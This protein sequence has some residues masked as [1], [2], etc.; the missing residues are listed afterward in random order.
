MRKC[1]CS[2]LPE[3]GLRRREARRPLFS[4]GTSRFFFNVRLR[5]K[6][7]VPRENR[8]LRASL[9]LRPLFSRGTSR[10]FFNVRL[11]SWLCSKDG[12]HGQR[13]AAR[14]F[15]RKE[16]TDTKQAILPGRTW[17]MPSFPG[18]YLV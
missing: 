14:L 17:L 15:E 5:K 4:R 12:V 6:R 16:E 18:S 9:L 1:C 3:P 10:F 7:E 13:G 11:R 8:G 2:I